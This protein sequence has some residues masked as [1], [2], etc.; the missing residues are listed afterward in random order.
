V[1][2]AARREQTRKKKLQWQSVFGKIEIIEQIWRLKKRGR[3]R[4]PFAARHGLRH[5]GASLRLTRALV[6]F[7]A[8]QS[9]F[10]AAQSMREHYGLKVS[11]WRV[12]S[13]TL[14]HARACAATVKAAPAQAAATLITQMDGSMIPVVKTKS[15]SVDKRATRK[16]YWREARLCLARAQGNCSPVYGVTLGGPHVAGDLWLQTAVSAGLTP[17]TRVHGVGDGA[18]WIAEQ[19]NGQFGAQGAYLLDFYHVSEYLAQAA[20]ARPSRQWLKRQQGYLLQNRLG[21]TLQ[22]LGRRLETP[23]AKEQPVRAAHRYLSE[24][25]D[26]LNYADARA[27]GLPIGSGEIESGHRHVLQ[28]RLKIAGAWWKESNAEAMLGL[29]A[30]RASGL[31]QTYWQS[32]RN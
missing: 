25:R 18:P 11:L 24:R 30:Q 26:Q 3:L 20:P 4:R 13:A 14:E 8:E 19:F 32:L 9:F 5:R 22:S 15:G 7:G 16:V 31:W 2:A 28:R 17:Q 12:R 29:R 6:D 23:S 1:P 10:Q 27:A 21:P